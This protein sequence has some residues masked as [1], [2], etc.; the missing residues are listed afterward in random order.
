MNYR[1]NDRRALANMAIRR[2]ERNRQVLVAAMVVPVAV[3]IGLGLGWVL[4]KF[5]EIFTR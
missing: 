4:V 3:V 5:A 2:D 1:T